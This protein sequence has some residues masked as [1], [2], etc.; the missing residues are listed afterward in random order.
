[1]LYYQDDQTLEQVARKHCG[2]SILRDRHTWT[3]YSLEQPVLGGPAPEVH[4]CPNYLVI[5]WLCST[6]SY[7]L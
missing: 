6:A 3:G 7:H 1:M 4:S 2:V 5:L